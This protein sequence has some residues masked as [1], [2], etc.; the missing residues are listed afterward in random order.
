M[1]ICVHMYAY[2]YTCIQISICYTGALRPRLPFRR[3]SVQLVS[4][5]ADGGSEIDIGTLRTSPTPRRH[6][7]KNEAQAAKPAT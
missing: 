1:L 4:T 3:G 2:I 6:G 5:L 7:M